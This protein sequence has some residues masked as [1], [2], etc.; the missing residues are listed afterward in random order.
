MACNL[1]VNVT[2]LIYGSQQKTITSNM[3]EAM[4]DTPTDDIETEPLVSDET[5]PDLST[6]LP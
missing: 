2:C 6:S 1:D 4:T 3:H 5:L